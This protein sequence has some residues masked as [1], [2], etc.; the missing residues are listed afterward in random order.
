MNKTYEMKYEDK[1]IFFNGNLYYL[2][3]ALNDPV[4]EPVPNTRDDII[5]LA[6]FITGEDETIK[7]KRGR[8]KLHK[9]KE[10][11]EKKPRG[12]PPKPPITTAIM[13]ERLLEMLRK[14][15]LENGIIPENNDKQLEIFNN[16]FEPFCVS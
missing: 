14:Y 2:F 9:E 10:I 8:P 15:Q 5:S 1:S 6:N 11:I 12:R 3:N 16:L 4:N 13:N 7:R